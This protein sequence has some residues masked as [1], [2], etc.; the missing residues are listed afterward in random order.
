M[1]IS[2]NLRQL[3]FMKIP[4]KP[5]ENRRETLGTWLLR[6]ISQKNQAKRSNS[7]N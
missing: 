4:E 5:E 7:F 1:D 3:K 2:N 6:E